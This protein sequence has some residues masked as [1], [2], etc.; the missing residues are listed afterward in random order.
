MGDLNTLMRFFSTSGDK[1][2]E[3][4]PAAAAGYFEATAMPPDWVDWEVMERARLFFTDNAAHINTGLAFAAMPVTYAVPGSRG[5]SPRRTPSR[6]PRGGWRVPGS[7][8]RT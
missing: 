8:S 5:C 1:L 2:P 6:T 4:L 3:R 7:S